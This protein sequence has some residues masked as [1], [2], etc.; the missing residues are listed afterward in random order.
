[1]YKYYFRLVAEDVKWFEVHYN[2]NC[3]FVDSFEQKITID[4]IGDL[5]SVYQ[6]TLKQ[7]PYE[8][9][10]KEEMKKYIALTR[11]EGLDLIKVFEAIDE[12]A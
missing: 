11:S 8:T 9:Y 10:D 1:M 3:L 4:Y 12:L 7:I 5:D 2:K 6:M